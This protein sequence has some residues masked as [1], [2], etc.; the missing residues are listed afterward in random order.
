[1][2]EEKVS[3]QHHTTFDGI[4]H[5]DEGGNEFWQARQLAKVLE[6]SEYRHF[7]PVI[8]R[9]KVACQT[10]G[11]QV[12]DHFEDVLGMVGIGSGAQRPVDDVR[13]SRY[14]CYL[15]VQNGDPS[16]PVI[17]NGQTYFALQTRRQELADDKKFAQLSEDE[18]RLAIRNELAAHNKHLAAAAKDA[19]VDTPLDYAIFQDHGYKGLYGGLGAKDIHGQKGLKKSQKILDHMGSTELAA[20]LFRATQT[21]E[22]LRRDKVSNKTQAN[23]THFD[24]GR[25]VRQTIDELGGTMPENLPK[26]DASIQQL[27]SAKKKQIKKKDKQ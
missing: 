26:P 4:R 2:T 17:A 11:Q 15:I 1:M 12:I 23:K 21:E 18:K 9:A 8:E 25:K 10:S 27:E 7:V 20:N 24:V 19:G 3:E 14:A 6:Y 22:K 5:L 13:L 16:K